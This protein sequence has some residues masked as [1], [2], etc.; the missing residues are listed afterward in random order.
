VS[1]NLLVLA[2]GASVGCDASAA[3]AVV[4][5]ETTE[6]NCYKAPELSGHFILA[7]CMTVLTPLLM[8]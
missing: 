8:H 2:V 5:T 1:S 4:C 3:P 7:A 6:Q